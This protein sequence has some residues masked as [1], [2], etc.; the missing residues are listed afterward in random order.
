[1]LFITSKTRKSNFKLK[2][3]NNIAVTIFMHK[4]FKNIYLGIF[5]LGSSEL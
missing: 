2:S 5:F 1:M 3:R 4:A